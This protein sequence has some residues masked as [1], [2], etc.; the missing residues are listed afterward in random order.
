V[1]PEPLVAELRAIREELVQ[2][3][4]EAVEHNASRERTAAEILQ[5]TAA[6]QGKVRQLALLG[7]I[8]LLLIV[9]WLMFKITELMRLAR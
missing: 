8:P 6:A 7:L 3:R 2:L 1:D 5:K 4:R 9:V